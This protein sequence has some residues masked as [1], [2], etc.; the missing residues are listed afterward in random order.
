MW[1]VALYNEGSVGEILMSGGPVDETMHETEA[2]RRLAVKHGVPDEDI[3]IDEDGLNTR[4]ST[5]NT[6]EQFQLHEQRHTHRPRVL[7]VSNFY[8]IPRIRMT[9]AQEGLQVYSIPAKQKFV[10]GY[11]PWMML[12]E[13]AA[14]WVNYGEGIVK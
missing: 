11:T 2:M 3:L 5:R 14:F 6:I 8:H 12:R 7:V 13:T 10:Y 1:A 9:F 4:A